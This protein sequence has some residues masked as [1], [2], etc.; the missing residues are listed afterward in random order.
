MDIDRGRAFG[1]AIRDRPTPRVRASPSSSRPGLRRPRA[2]ATVSYSRLRQSSLRAVWGCAEDGNVLVHDA[3][4]HAR[5][6]ASRRA[7]R[8]C[9]SSSVSRGPALQEGE[10]GGHFER[11]RGTE[12]GAFGHVAADS[13]RQR[14]DGNA[15][16]EQVLAP[17][18]T[19]SRSSA[20]RLRG[21]SPGD[22]PRRAPRVSVRNR[23]DAVPPAAGSTAIVQ[24]D[25]ARWAARSPGCNRCA[26]Q[27]D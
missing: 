3:A 18:R 15:A 12:P 2:A 21:A 27:S 4:G 23:H 13:Q 25:R 9:A 16:R 8:A 17:R 11:R 24:P 14:F 5:R 19:R 22:W 7:G 26:R 6:I 20:A 10:R 1:H